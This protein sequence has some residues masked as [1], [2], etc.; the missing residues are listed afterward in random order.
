[1]LIVLTSRTPNALVRVPLAQVCGVGLLLHDARH[2]VYKTKWRGNWVAV[3]VV[4]YSSNTLRE[5]EMLA[6]LRSQYLV[7]PFPPLP[8]TNTLRINLQEFRGCFWRRRGK[9]EPCISSAS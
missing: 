9:K 1:M 6:T 2:T 5:L 7:S 4:D 8:L 3:K